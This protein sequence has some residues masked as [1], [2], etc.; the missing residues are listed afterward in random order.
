M[1][2]K[3][4]TWSPLARI[5]DVFFLM[6]HDLYNNV[7]GI[8]GG[9]FASG[10]SGLELALADNADHWNYREGSLAGRTTTFDFMLRMMAREANHRL[11]PVFLAYLMNRPDTRP[12]VAKLLK[13]A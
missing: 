6:H 4:T 3:L 7:V 12:I 9:M 8:F 11:W 5:H 2:L 13:E 10:D 1:K